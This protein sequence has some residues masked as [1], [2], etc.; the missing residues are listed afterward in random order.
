MLTRV[1]PIACCAMALVLSGCVWGQ[2]TDA[3][4]GQP[5]QGATVTFRDAVGNVGTV[6]TGDS[7]LY[8][9]DG[10]TSPTPAAGRVR[11]EVSAPG[12]A[13][14]TVE[15]DVQYDANEDHT[16][17]VEDFLLVRGGG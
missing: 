1:A 6:T 3:V 13:A 12:Y 11:F 4:T 5:I 14:L 9:F 8:S 17:G 10:I 2:V 16:W 15:R 7:G